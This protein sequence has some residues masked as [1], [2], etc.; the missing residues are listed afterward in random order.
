MFCNLSF[1]IIFPFSLSPHLLFGHVVVVVVVLF[2]AIIVPF[3]PLTFQLSERLHCCS[4]VVVVVVELLL[5]LKVCYHSFLL[6]LPHTLQSVDI[7]LLKNEISKG[8]KYLSLAS[9][10]RDECE[11]LRDKARDERKEEERR[12]KMEKE[13]EERRQLK[14][15]SAPDTM[16]TTTTLTTP[17]TRSSGSQ[18]ST[19]T[20]RKRGRGRRRRPFLIRMPRRLLWLRRWTK[21]CNLWSNHWRIW[22]SMRSPRH[23]RSPPSG[24][25]DVTASTPNI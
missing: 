7:M 8:E 20:G 17:V 18:A 11:K 6:Y 2:Y 13:K 25:Y 16:M 9:D 1:T 5:L 24:G 23:L 22:S 21:H 3:S 19:T 15:L 12:K 10:L 14:A 4:N